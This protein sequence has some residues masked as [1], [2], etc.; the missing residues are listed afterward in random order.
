MMKRRLD[1]ACDMAAARDSMQHLLVTGKTTLTN[2]PRQSK[3]GHK[4]AMHSI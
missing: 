2:C 3:D 1:H 4:Q